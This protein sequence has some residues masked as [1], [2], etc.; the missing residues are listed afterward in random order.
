MHELTH[1]ELFVDHRGGLRQRPP[2]TEATPRTGI[3]AL[4][5]A[6]G[7]ILLVQPPDGDWLELPGGGLEPQEDITAAL[8]RELREEAGIRLHGSELTPSLTSN[9]QSR[10]YASNRGAYWHYSQ[11]FW[12]LE[13]AAKPT[14]GAP[15]EAG[16]GR[17][18]ITPMAIHEYFLHHVH[19]TAIDHLLGI[20]G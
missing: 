20:H 5:F 1:N 12:L 4:V 17:H 16:H 18:W 9:L 14:L 13:L 15:L 11:Y 10:Y 7:E 6:A 8:D 2:E 3:H 19:R